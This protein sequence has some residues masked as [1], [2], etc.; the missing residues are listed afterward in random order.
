MNASTA[1]AEL[2][3]LEQ[4]RLALIELI[5]LQRASVATQVG[6]IRQNVQPLT[7]GIVSGLP[8]G[9]GVDF[10]ERHGV[11]F[12]VAA[13]TIAGLVAKWVLRAPAVERSL[14]SVQRGM[15][16]WLIARAVGRIATYVLERQSANSNNNTQTK[17]QPST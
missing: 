9:F 10:A 16:W 8:S 1:Y 3:P 14:Q 12:A 13:A 2:L 11:F 4:R 17:H 7:S 6:K 5:D 15:R